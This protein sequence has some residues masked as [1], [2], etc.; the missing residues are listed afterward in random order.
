M[1]N[2]YSHLYLYAKGW[3]KKTDPIVDTKKII[4]YRCGIGEQYITSRD[5]IEQLID[6]VF[7]YI[8]NSGN[9]PYFFRKFIMN[10]MFYSDTIKAKYGPHENLSVDTIMINEC[11]SVISLEE[12]KN[13]KDGL[14]DPDPNI[15][16]LSEEAIKS[17]R[18]KNSQLSTDKI[19][20]QS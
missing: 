18:R 20:E 11:L 4:S 6:L 15:L 16:P 19:N 8:I 13:I 14:C 7:E 3:Y 9:P 2:S 10:T 12:V 5:V 17:F 1:A